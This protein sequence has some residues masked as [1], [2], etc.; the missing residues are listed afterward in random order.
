MWAVT[1][2]QEQRISRSPADETFARLQQ[3][4]SLQATH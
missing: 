3:V 4:V 1:D 2:V